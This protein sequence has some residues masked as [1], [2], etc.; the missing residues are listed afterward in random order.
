MTALVIA[1]A[2]QEALNHRSLEL[3][4]GEFKK[5]TLNGGLVVQ[6]RQKVRLL[7]E[8]DDADRDRWAA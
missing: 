6:Y 4:G 1:M 8:L 7:L 3:T 2:Y 5:E